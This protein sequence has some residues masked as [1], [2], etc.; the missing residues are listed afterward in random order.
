M[1]DY[2]EAE[3][4]L[5]QESA[6]E[7]A[8]AHPEQA[9]MLNLNELRDRDPYIERLLEG[10]AYLSAQIRQHIDDDI[11]E[12]S[13]TLLHQLWPHFLR[14]YPSATIM[15]FTPRIGQLQQTQVL[16]R[17][18]VMLTKAVGEDNVICRFRTTS[19]VKLNPMRIHRL[20]LSE[21]AGGGTLIRLGFQFD[22]GITAFDVDL[23]DLKLYINADPALALWLHAQLTGD[24]V[25]ARVLFPENS[26]VHPAVLDGPRSVVA[27]HLEADDAMVNTSGRSFH[28]FHLLQDYFC[29]REKYMF[30]TVRGLE[31]VVW[32]AQCQYFE[33]EFH[34][35]ELAPQDHNMRKETFALHCAPAVNLYTMDSEPINLTHRRTSYPVIADVGAREGVQVYSVDRVVGLDAQ[36][37]ERN[38]YFP[39]YTFE[40]RR[41]N[42]RYYNVSRRDT[43]S[44][45]TDTY[46][47]VGGR[48][49]YRPESLSCTITATNGPY[50]RRFLSENTITESASDFPAYASFRNL[51]RPTRSLSPPERKRFQWELISHL[52][53]NYSSLMS[54]DVLKRVLRLYDWSGE[55]QNHRRVE[56]IRAI[57]CEPVEKIRRGA[58]M[59]GMDIRLTLHEE[60]YRSLADMRLFGCI[61]Q[62]FFSMYAAINCF[63]QVKILCHPSNR[64]FVW[65]PIF[66][67]N[68]PI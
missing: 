12:I 11:P 49:D 19:E 6:Q 64:E 20:E 23:A 8:R 59:R 68:S 35:R 55:E 50:P 54:L 14:D 26:T 43:G 65:Q 45:V 32:P 51:T 33:L 60:N 21:P 56:G 24:L 3:L 13:E 17:G 39:L 5:I 2:Y 9:G 57:E 22:A 37:G 40:H 47:S 38:E 29:F 30:F 31:D 18:T 52:S 46:I 67:E 25:R 10:M 15:A 1:R 7:F 34:L 53:L 66:G 36:T 58:L 63:V 16:P 4:R 48:S 62:H 41:R 27:A 44:G 61:L 42:G 28:G